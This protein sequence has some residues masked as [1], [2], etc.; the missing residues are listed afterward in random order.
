MWCTTITKTKL[1]R[2]S[3]SLCMLSAK[4]SS[5]FV[6]LR[7]QDLDP[8]CHGY[9]QSSIMLLFMVKL[10]LEFLRCHTL[11]LQVVPSLS[12]WLKSYLCTCPWRVLKSCRSSWS[13]P[14]RRRSYIGKSA[15]TN[16]F[17]NLRSNIK[18]IFARSLIWSRPLIISPKWEGSLNFRSN[19]LLFPTGQKYANQEEDCAAVG[20]KGKSVE[21]RHCASEIPLLCIKK[22]KGGWIRV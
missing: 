11:L 7:S 13:S 17:S 21:D 3:I 6:W 1:L 19:V 10:L 12:S 22:M 14:L 8:A 15:T 5:Q 2:I 20:S 16:Y 4:Q 9:A 18:I